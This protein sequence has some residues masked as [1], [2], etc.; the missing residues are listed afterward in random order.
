MAKR[1]EQIKCP[2]VEGG[3][4]SPQSLRGIIFRFQS[5]E[6]KGLGDIGLQESKQGQSLLI[7]PPRAQICLHLENEG[8]WN[9]ESGR[10]QYASR[11]RTGGQE[12]QAIFSLKKVF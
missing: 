12:L 10:C 2:T 11:G 6:E 7:V 8:K 5:D 3:P 4:A 1:H 9:R